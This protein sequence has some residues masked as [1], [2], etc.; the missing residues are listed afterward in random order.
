MSRTHSPISYP[1]EGNLNC[2]ALEA[3]SFWFAHR[4]ERRWPR[5]ALWLAMF[6]AAAGAT[7]AK[8]LVGIVIPGAVVFLY[9]LLTSQWR[10]L[11]RVPL[12]G[13]LQFRRQSVLLL[14]DK[15]RS[16]S[17]RSRIR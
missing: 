13:P 15:T 4:N 6:A 3:G 9:L 8:G 17:G 5:F 16:S 14:P 1:E 11:L 10:I 7:L 12:S 2:L